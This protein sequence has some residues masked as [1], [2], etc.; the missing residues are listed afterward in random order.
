VPLEV[1]AAPRLLAVCKTM[2]LEAGE[3]YFQTAF[4]HE[5]YISV[6]EGFVVVRATGP[7]PS[8]SVVTAVAGPGEL[9]LPPEP[10]EVVVA[11]TKA[12]LAL[13]GPDARARVLQ[14]PGLAEQLVEALEAALRQKQEA[15]ASLGPTRHRDR[16]RLRLTQLAAQ[17][18]HVVRDGIRIDF[19]LSHALLAEMIASSRETVTRALDELQRSGFVSRDGSTYRVRPPD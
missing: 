18:G 6:E 17:Y 9:L 2:T 3:P 1:E 16:V 14:S 13:I 8:R 4:P 11:L 7:P 19:P 10:D 15:A 5:T 12:R